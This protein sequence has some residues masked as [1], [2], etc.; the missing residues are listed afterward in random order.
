VTL[1]SQVSDRIAVAQ[2]ILHYWPIQDV[3]M[4]ESVPRLR[5]EIGQ[6]FQVARVGQGIEIRD[7]PIRPGGQHETDKI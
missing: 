5:S 7:P 2:Q 4:N 1:G 6:I 3:P